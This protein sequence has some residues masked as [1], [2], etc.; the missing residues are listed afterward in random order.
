[1]EVLKHMEFAACRE[2]R[3]VLQAPD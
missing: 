1:M 3:P 2:R